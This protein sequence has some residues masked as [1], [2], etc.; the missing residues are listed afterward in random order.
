[1]SGLEALSKL[2][3]QP[4]TAVVTMHH[5]PDADALGSALAWAMYLKKKGHTTHV[6]APS[7]YPFF[8]NWMNGQDQVI[9]YEEKREQADALIQEATVIYCLDF[10]DL[11]RLNQ[12]CDS[13]SRSQATKVLIDHHLQ[14]HPFAHITF[15]D[16]SA[17]ATAQLIFELIEA[18]GD[19]KLLDVPIGECLYAGIMTDTGSFRHPSTNKK[20]HLIAAQLMDIGVNTSRIHQLIFDNNSEIRLR[21]LG[22]VLD[23]KLVVLSDM[24][25][26][27]MC[28]SDDELT[29]FDTKTGDTEGFVNYALSISGINMATV[30]IERKDGVKLSFRSKG[31]FNVSEFARN[32]FQGGGHK[33]ASGGRSS[34]NLADTEKR[35]IEILRT[36]S[37]QLDFNAK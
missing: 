36:Y 35:F 31:E 27:Y 33:N 10:N 21:F 34:D 28:L 18:L 16:T 26:A 23:K 30:I 19:S 12:M 3:N 17:A 25:A 13:V 24:H 6:I 9:N 37:Q 22:Y 14:P 2:V 7:D 32:H 11:A 8:L 1:M 15:S 29:K 20:V 4:S 5:K